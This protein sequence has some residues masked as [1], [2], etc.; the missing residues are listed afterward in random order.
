MTNAEQ[1]GEIYM[2]SNLR[3]YKEVTT[4]Q[5]ILIPN[6][7]RLANRVKQNFI[8]KVS[9]KNVPGLEQTEIEIHGKKYAAYSQ[10]FGRMDSA[11]YAF[12]IGPYGSQDLLIETRC[13]ERSGSGV[14]K[15]QAKGFAG[16]MGNVLMGFM[17]SGRSIQDEVNLAKS[18]GQ[19][20]TGGGVQVLGDE[21]HRQSELTFKA[22]LMALEDTVSGFKA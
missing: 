15:G 1:A 14:L 7:G 11:I 20:V 17:G 2:S 21:A 13:F 8:W 19:A 3:G 12:Y 10:S 9:Q 5:P 18:F 16:V 4:N 6:L 22:L